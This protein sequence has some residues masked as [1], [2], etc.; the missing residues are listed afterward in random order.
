VSPITVYVYNWI[1]AL[2][3]GFPEDGLD[4]DKKTHFSNGH[5]IFILLF[6]SMVHS[7]FFQG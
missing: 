3:R 5:F 7:L 6:M 1:V 4:M 2:L